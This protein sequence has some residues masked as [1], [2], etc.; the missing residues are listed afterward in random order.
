MANLSMYSD[1]ECHQKMTARKVQDWLFLL[2]ALQDDITRYYACLAI[3][4]L[5]KTVS[6]V[7]LLL[8]FIVALH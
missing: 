6:F 2:A 5:V 8:T 3:C 7:Y 1:S 4:M